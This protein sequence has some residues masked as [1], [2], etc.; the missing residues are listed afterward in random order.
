MEIIIDF[1]EAIGN[2]IMKNNANIKYPFGP[3]VNPE[4]DGQIMMFNITAKL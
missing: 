3:P 4:F 2:V 1:S